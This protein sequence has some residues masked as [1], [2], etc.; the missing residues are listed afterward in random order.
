MYIFIWYKCASPWKTLDMTLHNITS[1]GN[2]PIGQ[3]G[4]IVLQRVFPPRHTFLHVTTNRK[5]NVLSALVQV[6]G[7]K[8]QSGHQRLRFYQFVLNHLTGK[9]FNDICH[10]AIVNR[11]LTG[12]T[13]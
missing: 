6:C 5:S 1:M 10:N 8:A 2:V 7:H 3:C 9:S 4:I 12:L 11:N 13:D